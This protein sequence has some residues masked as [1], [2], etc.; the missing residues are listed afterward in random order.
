MTQNFSKL[1]K[2]ITKLISVH[3]SIFIFLSFG[4]LIVHLGSGMAAQQSFL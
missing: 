3:D 4:T 2:D 1:K